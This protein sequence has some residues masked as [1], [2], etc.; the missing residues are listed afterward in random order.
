MTIE[1]ESLKGTYDRYS[2]EWATWSYLIDVV[3]ETAEEFGFR[4]I[5]PPSVERQELWTQ[6]EE[7]SVTDEM[8]TFTDKGDN[9]ITLVPEQT[10]TRARLI[11]KRKD[12]KTPVNGLTPQR[13]EI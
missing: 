10:P 4:E 5:D 11:Q 9:E 8:Y 1:L 2:E 13:V 6:K 7:D 3:E 12:L